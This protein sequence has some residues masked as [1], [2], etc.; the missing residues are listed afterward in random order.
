MDRNHCIV[1]HKL[2]KKI[3]YNFLLR[4]TKFPQMQQHLYVKFNSICSEHSLVILQAGDTALHYSVATGHF[5]M[6]KCLVEQCGADPGLRN[7]VSAICCV[8][9]LFIPFMVASDNVRSNE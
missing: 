4:N 1:L 6:V 3:L 7:N 9:S 5:E 8:T 2:G